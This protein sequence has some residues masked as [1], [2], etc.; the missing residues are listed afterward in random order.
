MALTFS[1]IDA[2]VKIEGKDPNNQFATQRANMI[3]DTC[4]ELSTN[5]RY[6]WLLDQRTF[7]VPATSSDF[8]ALATDST[9]LK[10]VWYGN[11]RFTY[12]SE[13]AYVDDYY[14][15]SSSG[16]GY[17][18]LKWDV[19]AGTYKIALVNGPPAGSVVNFLTA[20]MLTSPESFP[21]FMEEVI[22]KGAVGRFCT[23]LEGDDLPYGQ[24][25][26]AEYRNLAKQQQSLN[27][28]VHTGGVKT[29]K[30]QW[31]LMSEGNEN[32]YRN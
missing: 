3:K 28:N 13:T 31:E 8:V 27:D 20:K 12:I 30:S 24:E 15:V 6:D 25:Q 29:S 19:A 23:F 9:L 10:R 4:I 22:V 26:M 21:D 18:R 32:A 16:K 17:Y 7:T 5:L 14:S 2:R 1:S 11:Q